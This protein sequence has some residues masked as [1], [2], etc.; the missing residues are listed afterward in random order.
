VSACSRRAPFGQT[1]TMTPGGYGLRE[2]LKAA[3][4][5]GCLG[6]EGP[7]YRLKALGFRVLDRLGRYEPGHVDVLAGV[8]PPG[9]TAVD[10]GGHFGVYSRRFA[11]RVGPTG[12]VIVVEPFPAAA[13]SL[14]AWARS[15]PWCRVV[16]SAASDVADE[17]VVLRVPRLFGIVP[18][19][20]LASVVTP[21]GSADRRVVDVPTSTIT[22][23]RLLAGSDRVDVVKIDVEGHDLRVLR[24]AVDVLRRLRPVV[25]FEAHDPAATIGA[26]RELGVELGYTV[27]GLGTAGA[28]RS[29]CHLVPGE[30]IFY[31]VPDERVGEMVGGSVMP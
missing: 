17:T 26:F 14:R 27:C 2:V 23:D 16:E 13:A 31:L 8:L 20:A 15:T 29:S 30:E 9:G 4:F 1:A 25:Q 5:L 19:P 10:V 3:V 12:T 11:T 28:L 21:N 7:Y 18:E 6:R 22:L 24:G